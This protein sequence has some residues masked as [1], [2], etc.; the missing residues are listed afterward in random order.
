[1]TRS[2]HTLAVDQGTVD[3]AV[4]VHGDHGQPFLLLYGG[5]GPQTVAAFAALLAEQ[6][7]ARV[8]A[9]V[10]PGFDATARPDGLTDVPQL[11]RLYGRLLD[12]L[13]LT[14]VAVVGNSI[15]GWIAAELA[16]LGS[17]RIS[18]VTLINAVGVRVPGHPIAD[19]FGLTPV[20]LSRLSFH[21]PAKF[22]FD[23][24]ALTDAQIAVAAGNRAALQVY[25]GPAAMADPTLT[26]RLA[27]AAHPTL[28]AWGESDRVVDADYG[29]AYAR[30]IPDAEF[31]L[32]TGTG[33]MPQ[34]ETPD[35]LLP[36][37]WE[38]ADAHAARR[39]TA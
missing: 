23:P 31:R 34:V 17:A 15:G 6:R 1:M 22:R 19:T 4:D 33:H 13:D 21:D 37:V 36:V 2:T 35:E 18:S 11:A 10:H 39:A 9:P 24:S 26:D 28:V 3:L 8:Y 38:F 12:A 5:G 29:R 14:D 7:P 16:V 27:Q 30:A 25:S 32:L 20:E